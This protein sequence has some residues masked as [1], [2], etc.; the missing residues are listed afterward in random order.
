M[1]MTEE[2]ARKLTNAMES[3]LL[4]IK[5]ILSAEEAARYL[6]LKRSSL[7]TLAHKGEI[8]CYKPSGKNLYFEREELDRWVKSKGLRTAKG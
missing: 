7:Y 5:P 1:L 6:G 4:T 8:N 2:T 3:L